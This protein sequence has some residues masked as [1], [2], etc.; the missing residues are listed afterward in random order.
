MHWKEQTLQKRPK[1]TSFGEAMTCWFSPWE[2]EDNCDPHSPLMWGSTSFCRQDEIVKH[3]GL[4]CEVF[5]LFFWL[6]DM[7]VLVP[8]QWWNSRPLQWK[9]RVLATVQLGKSLEWEVFLILFWGEGKLLPT[10]CVTSGQA[11]FFL[12]KSI[13]FSFRKKNSHEFGLENSISRG[14]FSWECKKKK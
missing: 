6:H 3:L 1:A 2:T 4:G 9:C 8:D 14:L 10:R 7:W 12:W 11:K 13:L 5:F